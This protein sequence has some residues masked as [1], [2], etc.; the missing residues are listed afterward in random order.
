MTPD[1]IFRGISGSGLGNECHHGFYLHPPPPAPEPRGQMVNL[2]KH[3]QAY[4]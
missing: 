1:W 3:I 4:L 2:T